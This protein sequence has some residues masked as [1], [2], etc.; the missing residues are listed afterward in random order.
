LKSKYV[1]GIIAIA[2]ALTLL[3]VGFVSAEGENGTGAPGSVEVPV[4]MASPFMAGGVTYWENEFYGKKGWS[5]EIYTLTVD[6]EQTWFNIRIQDCCW[7][8]DFYELWEVSPDIQYIGVTPQ[9]E[10]D[11]HH[12]ATDCKIGHSLHTG[13][14][15]VLSD[16]MFTVVKEIGVYK[17]RVR[18][19]LF[20][21]LDSEEKIGDIPYWPYGWSPAGFTIWF[22]LTTPAPELPIAVPLIV[23]LMV[24][25][26]VPIKR[27]IWKN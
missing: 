6:K 2:V 11:G 24:I 18:N 9:V 26:L 25:A 7:Y 15:T 12:T 13:S 21:I 27:K 17:Y 22:H 5:T 16:A 1:M 8:G 3:S 20:D 23:S 10:T 4:T 14:G 19:A